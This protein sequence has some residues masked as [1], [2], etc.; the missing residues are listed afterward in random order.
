MTLLYQ[1]DFNRPNG[2]LVGSTS[3]GIGGENGG[4][5]WVA[6]ISVGLGNF[7]TDGSRVVHGPFSNNR[8]AGPPVLLDYEL[9]DK[10]SGQQVTVPNVAGA[11][12]ARFYTHRVD[13]NNYIHA[14]YDGANVYIRVVTAGVG[15]TAASQALAQPA[16]PFDVAVWSLAIG[17]ISVA[18]D[19]VTILDT[20]NATADPVFATS[21]TF[22]IMAIGS[23]VIYYDDYNGGAPWLIGLSSFPNDTTDY[24]SLVAQRLAD[25]QRLDS[26]LGGRQSTV[27]TSALGL[28]DAV[29]TARIHLIGRC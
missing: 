22:G 24:N 14:G 5:E 21:G 29:P 2:S 9:S 13:D 27:L 10:I 23:E 1:D 15:V 28:N 26:L 6:G 16:L 4:W 18:V 25:R 19:G 8:R 17:Q 12:I 20:I 7:T 11:G 3:S